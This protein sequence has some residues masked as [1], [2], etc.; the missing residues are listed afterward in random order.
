MD[1]AAGR[2][3]STEISSQTSE[4]SRQTNAQEKKRRETTG[5]AEGG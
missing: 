2:T 3:T 1:D 4:R 5:E